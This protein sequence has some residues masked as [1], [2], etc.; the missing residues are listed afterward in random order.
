M[1]SAFFVLSV[2]FLCDFRESDDGEKYSGIRKEKNE[3][4]LT[5][6][7]KK[8]IMYNCTRKQNKIMIFASVPT[9]L[10]KAKV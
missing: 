6:R 1:L 7:E 5:E 9:F 10:S 8:Y 4:L 3:K 2:V